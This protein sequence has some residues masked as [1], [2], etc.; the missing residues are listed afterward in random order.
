LPRIRCETVLHPGFPL[1]P[2]ELSLFTLRLLAL[3]GLESLNPEIR[4]VEDREIARL[5]SEYLGISGPTNVLSFPLEDEDS[6]GLVVLSMDAVLRESFLYGQSPLEQLTRLLAH[7]LLHLAGLDH[8]PAMDE[9][10][11]LA[12]EH[13]RALS[14]AV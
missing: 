6:S 12:V 9:L 4:L 11:E 8:G 7:A 13:C 3:L 5:N 14:A 2:R 1:A 10:T